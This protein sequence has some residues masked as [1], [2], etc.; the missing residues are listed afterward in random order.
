M[1]FFFPKG[2]VVNP[3]CPPIQKVIPPGTP[4]RPHYGSDD[5][6]EVGR[7]ETGGKFG[8]TFFWKIATVKDMNKTLKNFMPF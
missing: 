6:P 8:G 1:P 2:L 7:L 4:Q 3:I 5:L